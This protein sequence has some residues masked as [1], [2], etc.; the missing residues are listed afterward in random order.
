MKDKL[1]IGIAVA[2]GLLITAGLSLV[3]TSAFLALACYGFDITF[4]WKLAIGVWA[5]M[6]LVHNAVNTKLVT[7]GKSK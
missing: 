7:N 3:I 5:T 2:V 6:M 4:T 1:F